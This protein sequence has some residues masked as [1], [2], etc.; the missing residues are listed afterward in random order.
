MVHE[1]AELAAPLVSTSLG[2]PYV[3]VG[4]GS[5]IPRR[6]LE[7]AGAAARPHWSARGLEP[8]PVA[9]LFRYLYVDP[10]PP[11]LQHADIADVPV[12]AAHPAAGRRTGSG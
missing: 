5:L 1:V 12:G 11:A 3:D 7:A 2:I 6:L 9:G 8:G 4:F 10:C